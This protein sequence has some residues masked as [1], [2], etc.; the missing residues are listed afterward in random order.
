MLNLN[1]DCTGG[2]SGELLKRRHD[3]A[4][5][6]LTDAFSRYQRIIACGFHPYRR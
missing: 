6:S 1:V 4:G 3:N 2:F 5:T